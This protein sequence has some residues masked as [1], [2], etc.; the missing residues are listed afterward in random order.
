MADFEAPDREAPQFWVTFGANFR[1]D[2]VET[3]AP[4]SDAYVENIGTDRNQVWRIGIPRGDVGKNATII[5]RR[6]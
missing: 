5:I 6:L 2:S 1:I 3:L 4:G